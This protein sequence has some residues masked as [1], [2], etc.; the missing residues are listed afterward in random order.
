MLFFLNLFETLNFKIYFIFFGGIYLLFISFRITSTFWQVSW[1]FISSKFSSCVLKI[2]FLDFLLVL[3]SWFWLLVT[4]CT[5]EWNLPSLRAPTFHLLV[6]YETLLHCCSQGF[7]GQFFQ[8]WVAGF[9]FLVCPSVGTLLK[10]V[11][12][13]WRCWCMKYWWPSFQ[14]HTA[15]QPAQY[16]NW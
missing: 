6:L 15:T 12:H 5:E 3:L 7:H 16:D 14:H 13:G 9:F 1:L 8:K 2:L 4:L 10:L 11:H